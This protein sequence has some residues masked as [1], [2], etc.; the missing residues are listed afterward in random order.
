MDIL[1][2][3]MERTRLIHQYYEQAAQ[4]SSLRTGCATVQRYHPKDRDG[5]RAFH[6]ALWMSQGQHVPRDKL[7]A[8]IANVETLCEW[9]EEKM[10]DTKYRA[11][12]ENTHPI[13]ESTQDIT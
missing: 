4:P 7:M 5:R 1:Y 10:F 6:P 9:L 3:L 8:A 13:A 12:H 11:R 2:F